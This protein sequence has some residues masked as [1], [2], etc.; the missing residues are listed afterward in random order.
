MILSEEI[1]AIFVPVAGFFLLGAV[2]IAVAAATLVGRETASE[3][4][5]VYRSEFLIVGVLLVPAS[6]GE[7]AFTLL[8]LAFAW[9]GQVE[10]GALFGL[11]GANPAKIM[12][13]GV[14]GLAL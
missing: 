5:A 13:M 8:L 10:M 7:W 6:I 12:A 1:I 3:L 14:A 4:W 9:R 2:V 11:R